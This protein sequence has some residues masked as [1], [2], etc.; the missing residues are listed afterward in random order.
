[1]RELTACLNADEND[2]K[3][4][5]TGK[6]GEACWNIVLEKAPEREKRRQTGAIL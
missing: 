3:I 1:M 5:N 4:N 6:R 2:K